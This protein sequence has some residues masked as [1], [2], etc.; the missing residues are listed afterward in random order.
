MNLLE[1]KNLSVQYGDVAALADVSLSIERGAVISLVGS[2]GS[3]KSTLI[4]TLSGLVPARSGRIVFKGESI[5]HVPAHKRVGL[6][7]VQVPEN[8]RLFP[9]MT[10]AENLEMGAMHPRS[11]NQRR[12]NME[13]AVHLFPVLAE[14]AA[15][16]AM[17]L[18]GG[19][20]RMVAIARGLMA[21]PDLLMLDEPSIGLAPLIV[22]D[23]FR[24][25]ARI[26]EMGTTILLVEQDVNASL[27]I[28]SY[29][30]V[31]ENGAIV[32]SGPSAEI[33]GSERVREAYLGL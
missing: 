3:G 6:G 2:N 25:I 28:S 14:R 29:S 13:K 33:L 21:N 12:Q 4:N 27:Q 18:S 16:S 15:Q 26:N 10:V 31:L 23:I 9:H 30:Y 11:R 20:Q 1:V 7:L 5:G 19:E 22:K 32:L 24:T 17:T 8:R